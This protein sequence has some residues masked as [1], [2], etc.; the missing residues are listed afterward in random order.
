MRNKKNGRSRNTYD[1]IYVAIQ[2]KCKDKF[3]HIRKII[4]IITGVAVVI[5]TIIAIY[6][7]LR[8]GYMKPVRIGYVDI[9]RLHEFKKIENRSIKIVENKIT[10]IA[11]NPEKLF[12]NK[13]IDIAGNSGKSKVYM[14]FLILETE[15][16]IQRSIADI[17]VP[18]TQYIYS[19]IITKQIEDNPMRNVWKF[20][21]LTSKDPLLIIPFCLT[22]P[23]L[24]NNYPNT[25]P[26]DI[27]DVFNNAFNK[28]GHVIMFYKI[29]KIKYRINGTLW[30]HC[31]PVKQNEMREAIRNN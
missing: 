13:I 27:N 19:S 20:R 2:E 24:S 14:G 31:I 1:I 10:E 25:A 6:E 16:N 9:A 29:T 4:K 3:S 23:D 8:P 12:E 17:E 28:S 11:K 18:Y 5:T 22:N 21:N 30:W 26:E 15:E 7:F